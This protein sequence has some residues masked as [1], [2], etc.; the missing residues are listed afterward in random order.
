MK[1][2]FSTLL[3]LVLTGGAAL[4]QDT[5]TADQIID[6]Y[7]TAIGGREAVAKIEDL[8]LSMS[9]ESQRNGQA[10][11]LEMEAKQ[12]KPNKF[13]SVAYAFGQ[14][15][16]RTTCDGS[17]VAS[18]RNMMGNQQS[19]TAEGAEA[20]LQILQGAMFP[21]LLYEQYKVERTVAGKD[22]A[23]GKDVWKVAFATPEGKKWFEFFDVATGL[24][25]K[26][27]A[28]VEGRAAGTGNAPATDGAAR[29]QRGPGGMGGGMLNVTFADYKDVKDGGGVKIP[30]TRQQGAGNF[31]MTIVVSSA[32]ANKGIKEGNFEIK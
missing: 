11:T 31:S 5:P 28:V 22:T 21:E 2:Y 32:K 27:M 10:F 1:S 12:K 20:T 19:T 18:M 30:F 4:A 14:E 24:K 13:T 16:S 15:V 29:G 9:G 26:R 3:L 6:K 25:I 8:T 23:A 17:K 7:L